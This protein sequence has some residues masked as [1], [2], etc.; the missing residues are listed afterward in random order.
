MAARRQLT[1]DRT[2]NRALRA[3]GLESSRPPIT[4]VASLALM[5]HSRRPVW[6][7]REAAVATQQEVVQG[8]S[9]LSTTEKAQALEA[10]KTQVLPP[11]PAS[12][13]GALWLIA[14]GTFAFVL[15]GGL[16]LIFILVYRSKS[17]EVIVPIVTAALGV[18]AGLLA[19]SP[20]TSGTTR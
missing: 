15:A 16:I 9:E 18:L 7:K 17:T 14:V 1:S 8:F 12:V 3:E 11:P 20:A 13:T 6:L 4:L 19:P 2:L 5:C 10:I